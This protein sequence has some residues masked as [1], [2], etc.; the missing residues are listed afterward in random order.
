MGT[1]Y[2]LVRSL[3]TCIFCT[4]RVV[5]ADGRVGALLSPLSSQQAMLMQRDGTLPIVLHTCTI[6]VQRCVCRPHPPISPPRHTTC[7]ARV[8]GVSWTN[9]VVYTAASWLTCHTKAS[10]YKNAPLPPHPALTSTS[11]SLLSTPPPPLPDPLL[12]Y[13]IIRRYPLF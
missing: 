1:E 13:H 6:P 10:L 12:Q 3:E 8:S 2:I 11:A 9:R 5:S 7:S 4:R